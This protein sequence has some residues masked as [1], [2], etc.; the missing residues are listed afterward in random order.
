MI[1]KRF[2]NSSKLINSVLVGI[3]LIYF[4]VFKKTPTIS[5]KSLINLYCLTNGVFNE[6]LDSRLK[7]KNAISLLETKSSF[8]QT[9]IGNIS[10]ALRIL[11]EDGYYILKD[12][13]SEDFI[14][15][16][17]DIVSQSKC[18]GPNGHVMKYDLELVENEIYRFN[19]TDIINNHNVQDLI[20][21]PFFYNLCSLYFNSKPIFDYAAMWILNGSFNINSKESAQFYHFDLDRTK[22]LKIFIYLEDVTKDNA[23][24][25]YIKGSHKINSKP[26]ELLSKGYT[27]ISDKEMSKFYDKDKF[28]CIQGKKGTVIIGDTKCWHKGGFVKKGDRKLLQFQI[29]SNLFGANVERKQIKNLN[30]NIRS[31][32]EFLDH[33]LQSIYLG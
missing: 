30:K 19:E 11:N 17:L 20:I 25:Y 8:F 16:I 3:G 18:K 27:R 13:I 5:N 7:T 6:N 28:Q 1:I 21:D 33:Y 24:H 9:D 14:N 32:K 4:K 23:P 26:K 2:L 15:K 10:N 22:W 29:S 12:R 31:N